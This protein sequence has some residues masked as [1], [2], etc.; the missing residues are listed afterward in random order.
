MVMEKL[1]IILKRK[2]GLTVVNSV[3]SF[4]TPNDKYDE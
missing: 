2:A 4:Y 3:I 1:Y